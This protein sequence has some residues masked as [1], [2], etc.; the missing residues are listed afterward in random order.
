M[1]EAQTEYEVISRG[2]EMAL[3]RCR[4]LNG[5]THQIRRHMAMLGCPLVGD[6]RY[7]S[8][9]FNAHALD[10]WGID[11]LCL[12]AH[13]L[14]FRHPDTD[15]AVDLQLDPPADMSTWAATAGCL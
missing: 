5:R 15:E 9:R 3:V 11:R 6:D 1:Q 2:P 7:G 8:D 12:H 4:P 14:S 13:A 10:R